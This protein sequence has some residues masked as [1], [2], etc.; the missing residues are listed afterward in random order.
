LNQR[1]LALLAGIH[2]TTISDYETG[3][4]VPHADTVARVTAALGMT[5]ADRE[6]AESYI[7]RIYPR[8][9]PTAVVGTD[10]P[11]FPTSAGEFAALGKQI[12][13]TA[14]A[15]CWHSLRLMI[16]LIDL[17]IRIAERGT[18]KSGPGKPDA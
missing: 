4:T 13:Q 7:R 12:T 10:P 1:E 2:Y 8:L 17:L 16:L 11:G 9:Q 18:G 15:V 6:E 3:K 5:A 14:Q